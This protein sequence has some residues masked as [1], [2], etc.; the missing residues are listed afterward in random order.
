MLSSELYPAAPV[1]TLINELYWMAN[2]LLERRLYALEIS[3]SQA[4]VLVIVKERQPVKPSLIALDRAGARPEGQAR[5]RTP[6]DQGRGRGRRQG[7]GTGQGPEQR[8]V[9]RPDEG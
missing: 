2:K 1:W 4:R 6:V 3:V 7:P 5:H 9:Q 8:A